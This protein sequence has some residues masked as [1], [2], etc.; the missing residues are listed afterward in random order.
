MSCEQSPSSSSLARNCQK[1]RIANY[2]ERK[3][4]M[5]RPRGSRSWEQRGEDSSFADFF[6]SSLLFLSFGPLHTARP[7][8]RRD[9]F[10]FA[11]YQDLPLGIRTHNRFTNLKL[12]FSTR[13][14]IRF[15][16]FV[17]TIILGF[18]PPCS[19]SRKE[20]EGHGQWK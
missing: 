10:F 5:Y 1:R 7:G 9:Y 3:L 16:L 6:S 13:Y 20:F 14:Q 15:P 18:F 2:V 17:G 19:I 4:R 12:V 11:S 8:K